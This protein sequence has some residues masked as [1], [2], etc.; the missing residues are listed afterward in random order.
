[1]HKEN[2]KK[3]MHEYDFDNA[4][5]EWSESNYDQT[6]KEP[7]WKRSKSAKK[8]VRS[9]N[10]ELHLSSCLKNPVKRYE[11][12]E[13]MVHHYAYMTRVAKVCKLESYT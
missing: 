4:E 13:Y 2:H 3:K 5:S 8:V 10:H 12:N 7:P 9:G 1:M 11:Y 6:E